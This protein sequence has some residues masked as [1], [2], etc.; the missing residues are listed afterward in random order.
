MIKQMSVSPKKLS[1]LVT[2]GAVALMTGC[3]FDVTDP[4]AI[5]EEDLNE[6]A[7]MTALM[8]GAVYNY[9]YSFDRLVMFTG[10]VSDEMT[11][12]GSWLPWHLADK[13][14]IMQM[15]APESDHINIPW[16][17]WRD[18]QRARASAEESYERMV[19][20]VANPDSDRRVAMMRLY[21]G[22]AYADFGELFCEAAYDGG[23]AVGPEVSFD[24]AMERLEDAI[25]I[26]N[27][28]GAGDI[29]DKARLVQARIHQATGNLDAALTAARS[30][31]DD[32]HWV[33][34]FRDAAGERAFF[35]GQN[36]ERG[37]LSVHP[38]FRNAEDPRTPALDMNRVGPDTETQIW[39]QLKYPTRNDDFVIGKWQEARLIEA[40]IL[41]ERGEVA[42]GIDLINQVRSAAGLE[43]VAAN[44]SQAEARQALRHE[45]EHELWLEARRMIDMRRWGV[46]PEGWGATCFPIS[47]EERDSNPNL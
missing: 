7:A 32:L 21:A 11:A 42:P 25:R 39:A 28:A 27:N 35:W 24:L 36:R 20:I 4:T 12:S 26:A 43:P 19:G 10:L 1:G 3:D 23:P 13:E 45:R 33:A 6:D 17:T 41:I 14:G 9:D 8:V 38:R 29:V 34:H 2:L 44:L 40:E 5:T 47:R 30:V 31:S 46:F 37:E 22:T 15:D 16:R 18:H